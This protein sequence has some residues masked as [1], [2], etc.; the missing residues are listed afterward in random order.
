MGWLFHRLIKYPLYRL[1]EA[2]R[3]HKED[4][5]TLNQD[6]KVAEDVLSFQDMREA[7]MYWR[8]N[9]SKHI[10]WADFK[11]KYNL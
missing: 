10:R 4:Q 5:E 11:S 6:E 9:M 3:I 8:K 2:R 1:R 7:Q